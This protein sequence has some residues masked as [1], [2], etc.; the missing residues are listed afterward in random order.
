MKNIFVANLS[1]GLRKDELQAAFEAY[2]EVYSAKIVNDK[3]TGR[4]RGFGFV[5]MPD[6]EAAE[7]AINA[8]NGTE[9]DGKEISVSEARPR[10][11][12]QDSRGGGDRDRNFRPRKPQQGGGGYRRR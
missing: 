2:G 11:E 5:E 7:E 3:V 10:E 4:S 12:R 1:F 8:L 6:D 9:L